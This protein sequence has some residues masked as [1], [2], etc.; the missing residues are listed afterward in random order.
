MKLVWLRATQPQLWQRA[1]RFVAIKE[2]VLYQLCGEW[3]VD[4]AI[5]AASG[6]LN[7]STLDWDSEA[8]QVAQITPAQLS[9]LVPTNQVLNLQTAWAEHWQVAADLPVLVGASDGVLSNLGL[10][11]E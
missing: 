2:Y 7:L 4:W 5:A 11:V 8:L 9:T 3:G 10:D 1:A 6:L